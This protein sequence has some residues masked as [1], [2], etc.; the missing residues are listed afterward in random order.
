MGI[1]WDHDLWDLVVLHTRS[2]FLLQPVPEGFYRGWVT[3]KAS[4]TFS[5]K[6]VSPLG[7]LCRHEGCRSPH[8]DAA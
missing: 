7:T 4:V 1:P 6:F 8:K 2:G 3:Y 5:Y